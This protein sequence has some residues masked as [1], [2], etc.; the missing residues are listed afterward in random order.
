MAKDRAEGAVGRSGNAAPEPKG[1]L[2]L[3]PLP[4][5]HSPQTNTPHGDSETKSVQNIFTILKYDA[6]ECL[7]VSSK[8]YLYYYNLIP[9]ILPQLR[10]NTF[11][12]MSLH[13]IKIIAIHITT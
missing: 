11:V 5:S 4:C 10:K 13:S 9:L 8:Q 3:L 6:N 12:L 1:G 7:T 2:R